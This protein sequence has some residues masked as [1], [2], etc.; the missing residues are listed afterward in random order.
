MKSN[1]NRKFYYYKYRMPGYKASYNERTREDYIDFN[2][3]EDE[4]CTK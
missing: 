3:K 4:E 1:M 2:E